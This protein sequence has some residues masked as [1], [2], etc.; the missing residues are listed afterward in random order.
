MGLFSEKTYDFDTP[1]SIRELDEAVK[2]MDPEG[3]GTKTYYGTDAPDNSLGNNGDIYYQYEVD[4]VEET[5]TIVA[6]YNK[7]DGE[8]II[9]PAGGVAF[10]RATVNVDTNYVTPTV[11]AKEVTE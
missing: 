7:I 6:S 5:K 2:K 4:P 10:T 1:K 3:G 9:V 8:W 11:T